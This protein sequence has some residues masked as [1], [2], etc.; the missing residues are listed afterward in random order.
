MDKLKLV[1]FDQDDLAV[2]SAHVQ[3]AVLKVGDL[4]FLPKEQRFAAVINRFVWEKPAEG[5]FRKNWERR[6]AGFHFDRVTAVRSTGIDRHNAEAVLDLLAISFEET[7]APAG[8]VTLIFAGG[9]A[10]ALDVECIEAS[11]SD[12]G[13]AWATKACPQHE[14][15]AAKA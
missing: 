3:D 15:D 6:R 11:I 4:A 10:I 9:G 13:P 2:V 14:L 7:E 1:A 5:T 8:T 12:L